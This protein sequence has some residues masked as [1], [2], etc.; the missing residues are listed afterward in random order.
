MPDY[1]VEAFRW[2]GTGYNAQYNTS[3]TATFSD[4]DGAYQGNGDGDETVQ[5]DGGSANATQGQPYK[6]AISFTDT[7]GN[8]HVEDFNFFYTSD[9]G[10]HFVPEPGSE[11]TVGATLGGYQG[12]SVGWDYSD[13]VCFVSGTRITTPSGK[14][15]VES[16]IVGDLITC[17][18]GAERRLTQVLSRRFS[19]KQLARHENLRPVRITAGSLGLGLPTQD[20]VVSRQHRILTKSR[21]SKRIFGTE[22][23]LV[24]AIKLTVMPGIYVE[25]EARD[26]EYF[27][28]G[29]ETHEVI[30]A[31]D[32]PAESLLRGDD[33]ILA[34]SPA[35]QQELNWLL[36]DSTSTFDDRESQ[37]IP[38]P[39]LQ[40]TILAK[41]RDKG[42]ALRK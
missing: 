23:A 27:H 6:I 33:A 31:E 39:K 12:H 28:L 7:S 5:I 8:A 1:T 18:D 24:A 15:S 22:E 32:A 36:P 25:T 37:N 29:F 30:F 9:G 10:W 13:V 16:L 35:A 4:N 2:S 26:V 38:S 21:I 40:K 34:N 3:Y 14:R 19:R 42:R 11:F 17:Q 41:H 20:L